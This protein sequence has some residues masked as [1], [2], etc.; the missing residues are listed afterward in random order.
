[1]ANTAPLVT[2]ITKPAI[3]PREADTTPRVNI[4]EFCEEYYEDIY[5]LS[6][7]KFAMTDEKMSILGWILKKFDEL[8]PESI[9]GYKDLRA[10]FL[11][12]FMQQKKYI[13]DPVEIHNIKQR[14]GETIEDFMER[15]KT[16]IK[17]MK[18][19][20]ECMRIFGFMHGVN[21][22]ELTKRLNEHVPKTMKDM[23]I[24]TTAFIRGEAAVASKKKGHASWKAHD[25]SKRHTSDKRTPKEILAAEASKFQLPPPMVT[26]VE[27]KSINKLCDFNN[28]KRHSTDECMQLKKQ[29]EELVR[30]GKLSHLIKEIKQGWDQSKTGKKETAVKDKPTTI[31]MARSWQRTVKQKVTQSFERV[32]E[33]VF[34]PLAASNGTEGPL[35]IEAEM[36]GHMIH[37]MYMDDGSSMEIFCEHCFNRLWPEIK[38][39]MVPATTSLTGFSGETIWPLGQLRLLVITGDATHSTKAWMNFMIVKSLSPYNGIIGR[40]GEERTRPANF[41][42]A[43]HPE[44]PDQEVVIGGTLSDKGCTELCSVL[45]KNLDIFVW[46]PSDM[47]GVPRSVA[48]HRLNI[49]EGYSPVR[50]KKKGQAPERAK[51]IQA[52]V[53]K[54]VEAGI[55]KEVY[56]HDWL[57][58]PVMD[59]YPLPEIDCKVESLCGY[60]F[61]CFL[62]AYKGYHQIQLAEADEEKTAFHMRQR[63]Y[64]YTKMPFGLK[65]AGATYQRLM[66][67]AFE[68]Q[69]RRN[70]EVYIDDLVV[71]SYTEAE[72]M[73]D[74]EETFRTLRKVNMKLNPKKCSFGLAEGVFLGDTVQLETAVN[75]ISQEYLLEFTS[76]YGIPKALHSE[77]PGQEDRIVDFPEGKTGEEYPP[78]LYQALGLSQKLEQPLF[79]VDERVLPTVVDWRTSAPKDGMPAEST[80]SVEA[81]RAL[82]THRTPIQ[83]QPEMLLC[84][85]GISRKY[86]LGDEV[87]PTFL[88]DDDRDMNLFNLIRAPNPTKMEDPAIAT[89][90]S[91]VPS[92]IE[93]SP[94]DFA[95]EVGVSDQGTVA[96]EVPTSEDV[97]ATSAPEAG[98]AE[99]VAATDPSA[100]TE[101]RKRGHDEADANAPP[102]VLR[103]D[104]ADPRPT[105]R[106]CGRTSLAAI[107]LGMA[108]TRP[109][110]VHGSAPAD[111]EIK[112]LE[113]LLEAEA[114]MR[115]A[116]EDKSARLSQELEDT[117]AP[118]SNLQ[119]SNNRLTQQVATLQEQVS[120]EEK[121]KAA[122]EEFKRYEDSRVEQHYAEMDAR[123]DAL[124]IDFYEEL[125]PHMLTAIAG[126]MWMIGHRLRLAVMKCGESLELRQAFVDVVSA[127]IAKGMSEALKD[128]KYPLVDQLEGLK[129]APMD[130]IMASLYLENDTGDDTPQCVRDLRPSSS[131]LTIPVYPESAEKKKKCRIVCR[132]H[133]VGSAH[134][135]RPDGIPVSAPTVV[136][137]G[138]A[139]LLAD[140]AT[141][142]DTD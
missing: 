125:Y 103:R 127:G 56:Y 43:L 80:Y 37:R 40:P 23:M 28:D 112:N 72:M 106:T 3:N 128:L 6:W 62:D 52:K 130:V 109:A 9:D 91:G 140:A 4:Q 124:S 110:P 69:I 105:G 78:M 86:Y 95:N 41:K 57:S 46:Q 119:V 21:N 100:V 14:D 111:H 135:A 83:K 142:T 45:K 27:K 66:D 75:T 25:Q 17:R 76:E 89:D 136:P 92:T 73:R 82:D 1:M 53:Q 68:G 48:E 2:T 81:V 65:N 98:Q 87:Y 11:A 141:H 35:V 8:P 97:P 42:A 18:G 115:K 117:R 90:S 84:V 30:V 101:S 67:K 102:K 104:H 5:Q 133:G 79:W 113:A 24:T 138:L 10:A 121:L 85:V 34:P 16:E 51:A 12:Y 123:L 70:I 47:T 96:P 99:E 126:C 116:A 94:L 50:Q 107:E 19:A 71:K 44:F 93:R 20:P 29:I 31:Y 132:T 32:K 129:D 39:Q 13:K 55:M 88:H 54:L 36:G 59:C 118:F 61:K 114:D 38:S 131:Q 22:P 74:I 7:R 134:N 137:Q 60:P 120:G 63:V 139:L 49:R 108:S 122:F 26:P 77:L 64:C 15:F 58:N 33:I